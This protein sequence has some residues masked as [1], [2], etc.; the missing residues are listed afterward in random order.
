MQTE[1]WVTHYC[2]KYDGKHKVWVDPLKEC[3]LGVQMLVPLPLVP[4]WPIKT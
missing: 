3:Q 2:S 1:G 4:V